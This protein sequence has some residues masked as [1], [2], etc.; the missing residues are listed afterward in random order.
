MKKASGSTTVTLSSATLEK[1]KKLKKD[2]SLKSMDA[3][4]EYLLSL[5]RDPVPEVAEEDDSGNEWEA[6]GK[7]RKKNVRPPLYSMIALAERPDMLEF[8]TGFNLATIELLIRTLEEVGRLTLL[9]FFFLFL[10][11]MVPALF[12]A[13]FF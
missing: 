2:L 5:P 8:Y 11:L 6:P 9:F 1:L 12:L 3:L 4:M 13:P 10:V 7:K